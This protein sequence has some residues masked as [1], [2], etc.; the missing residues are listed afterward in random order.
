MIATTIVA[1]ATAT[2]YRNGT[3][4]SVAGNP[5]RCRGR[6]FGSGFPCSRP[7]RCCEVWHGA[8]AL[9]SQLPEHPRCSPAEATIV[10][11]YLSEGRTNQSK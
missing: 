2:T 10:N 4:C 3:V 1:T 11:P 5:F 8:S 7:G 9:L 6:G